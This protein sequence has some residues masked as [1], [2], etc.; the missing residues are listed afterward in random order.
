MLINGI[1]G[2]NGGTTMTEEPDEEVGVE[3][4]EYV[5]IAEGDA[6]DDGNVVGTWFEGPAPLRIGM[7]GLII[8]SS[9]FS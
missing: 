4:D 1:V 2:G 5:E 7:L 6:D 9:P 8:S 3:I